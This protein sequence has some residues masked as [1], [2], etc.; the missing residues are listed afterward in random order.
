M[1]R[2]VGG[3]VVGLALS[4]GGAAAVGFGPWVQVQMVIDAE[5]VFGV[6]E[7][8]CRPGDA[9][10][11]VCYGARLTCLSRTLSLEGLPNPGTFTAPLQVVCVGHMVE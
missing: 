6:H 9:T 11:E 10:D 8:K 3:L 1:K 5:T 2:F 7:A 4:A